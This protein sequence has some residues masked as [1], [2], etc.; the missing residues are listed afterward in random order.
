[1]NY[2]PLQPFPPQVA[3]LIDEIESVL[4]KPIEIQTRNAAD[5]P[6]NV[7]E[8]L[9]LC[10]C[11]MIDGF[12]SVAIALPKNKKIPMHI[13]FHELLH[14]HRNV[15]L[16]VPQ[17]KPIK[18]DAAGFRLAASI[19]NDIEHLFIIPQETSFSAESFNYWH[20][21]YDEKLTEI[22]NSS[23]DNDMDILARRS[24]LLR[25]W[26]VTSFCLPQW[27]GTTQAS[28]V[29]RESGYL[30]EANK[31]L[32]KIQLNLPSKEYCL[33][34]FLRFSKLP[35]DKFCLSR[36]LVQD[37]KIEHFPIPLPQ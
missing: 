1:M 32:H 33:A 6:L 15:C 31:L 25:L 28:A 11:R 30:D 22:A 9:A 5:N 20:S 14:A 2:P 37:R 27:N 23:I 16:A 4:G 24:N 26:M 3:V 8:G 21:Y 34:T 29:L 7:P 17:L 12:T 10:D 36:F 13:M 19:E 18:D 35:M